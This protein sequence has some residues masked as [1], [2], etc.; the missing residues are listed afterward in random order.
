MIR[1]TVVSRSFPAKDMDLSTKRI[2]LLL[3]ILI[4]LS[5]AAGRAD[6]QVYT[7]RRGDTLWDIAFRFLGD[8][9]AWPKLWH[10]NAYIKDPNLIFPGD[11]LTISGNSTGTNSHF[12]DD[13]GTGSLSAGT[14]RT[15]TNAVASSDSFYSETKQAIEQSEALGKKTVSPASGNAQVSSALVALAMQGNRYF[16]ADFLEKIGFLWFSHDEKGQIYPGNAVI[17]KKEN[18]T[19][20]NRNENETYQQFDDIIIQPFSKASFHVGD[21]VS[22]LHSDR[23]VKFG[24]KTANVVRRTGRARITDV[25][26]SEITAVLFKMWDVVQSDDRIDTLAHEN[27]LAID[28]MV[29]PVVTIKGTIFLRIENTERPKLYQTCILDRGSKDGVALGDVFALLSRRNAPEGHSE[30]IACAVNV[31]ETSCTLVIEKLFEESVSAGDTAVIL[32]RIQ[33]KR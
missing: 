10:Q 29:D 13:A 31:G 18:S 7:I 8:P 19:V 5:F 32:K 24:S 15:G 22:I 12:A 1:G 16:T 33:F 2:L 28:T 6:E 30:A 26:P 9:F 14:S 20:S 3:P 21:T 11:K 23:F 27:D 17:R 4:V 25:K